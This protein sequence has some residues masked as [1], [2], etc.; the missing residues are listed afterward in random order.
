[1]RVLSQLRVLPRLQRLHSRSLASPA[2]HG[3]KRQAT[4]HFPSFNIYPYYGIL[5]G[6]QVGND[7]HYEEVYKNFRW[8][9]PDQFNFTAD[10]IDK[11]AASPEDK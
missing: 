3:V 6:H 5:R 10:V 2:S 9:I 11:L 8:E 4:K 1:M 7:Y